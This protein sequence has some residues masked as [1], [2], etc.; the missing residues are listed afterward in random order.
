MLKGMLTWAHGIRVYPAYDVL[1]ISIL[2]M[3]FCHE[4]FPRGPITKSHVKLQFHSRRMFQP[5]GIPYQDLIL[6]ST[7]VK[8]PKTD[9]RPKGAKNFKR[10]VKSETRIYSRY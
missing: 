1:S 5:D 3:Q 6:G 4:F 8:S 2:N 10:Y 9:R 7:S